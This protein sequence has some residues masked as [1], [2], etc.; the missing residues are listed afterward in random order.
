M[1][2]LLCV[3][4]LLML[5]LTGCGKEQVTAAD[6]LFGE[7]VE[8]VWEQFSPDAVTV[9]QQLPK[10]P[11]DEFYTVTYEGSSVS[12]GETS[13]AGIRLTEL[14]YMDEAGESHSFGMSQIEFYFDVSG[15][16][17]EAEFIKAM[18]EFLGKQDGFVHENGESYFYG[19][20]LLSAEEWD[21]AKRYA[22]YTSY[23]EAEPLI[24]VGYIYNAG[25]KTGG[26]RFSGSMPLLCVKHA[27]T[28]EEIL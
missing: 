23:S 13:D 14:C 2:R 4:V 16:E 15:Y 6:V 1:K 28:V 8:T 20:D 12:F 27:D 9:V 21:W 24:Q 7:S 3:V 19:S 26:V 22:E 10:E 17:D 11:E 18:R 25:T 5:C